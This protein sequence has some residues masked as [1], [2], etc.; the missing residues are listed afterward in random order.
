[1]REGQSPDIPTALHISYIEV[2]CRKK[3]C[4]RAKKLERET[5]PRERERELGRVGK[6]RRYSDRGNTEIENMCVCIR[7]R[8][9][10][11]LEHE[12]AKTIGI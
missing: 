3:A 12:L 4:E 1:M 2:R 10:C 6:D 9:E 7:E 11:N 5:E 8:D